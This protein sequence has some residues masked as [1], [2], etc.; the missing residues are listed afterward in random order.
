MRGIK[1]TT[2]GNQSYTH[3]IRCTSLCVCVP[4]SQDHCLCNIR[5]YPEKSA[6]LLFHTPTANAVPPQWGRDT[7]APHQ[8]KKLG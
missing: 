6:T 1:D 3:L 7:H 5:K 8:V 2:G 4:S